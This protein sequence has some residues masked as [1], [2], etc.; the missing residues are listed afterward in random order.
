MSLCVHRGGSDTNTHWVIFRI[1]GTRVCWVVFS[2]QI[3]ND[4]TKCLKALNSSCLFWPAATPALPSLPPLQSP[5]PGLMEHCE[6]TTPAL[7]GNSCIRSWTSSCQR[8]SN[9]WAGTLDSFQ[10]TVPAASPP[11]GSISLL[12]LFFLLV[13]PLEG[14]WKRPAATFSS[15]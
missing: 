3:N 6:I 4:M 5:V 8:K 7:L 13:P 15:C 12:G 2:S 9:R 14:L 11:G 10:Q 1:M